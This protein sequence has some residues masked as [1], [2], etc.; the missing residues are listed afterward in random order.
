MGILINHSW[1]VGRYEA[2][3][4]V[5]H[6][7]L[8][9]SMRCPSA[10]LSTLTDSWLHVFWQFLPSNTRLLLLCR[11]TCE[12]LSSGLSLGELIV[13]CCHDPISSSL[14]AVLLY[15][16]LPLTVEGFFTGIGLEGTWGTSISISDPWLSVRDLALSGSEAC[17]WFAC[18]AELLL[19]D[20]AAGCILAASTSAASWSFSLLCLFLRQWLQT[21]TG[22]NNCCSGKGTNLSAQPVQN[23][24]PHCLQL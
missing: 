2:P 19:S 13:F 21:L 11:L 16:L 1:V 10:L 4:L 15:L 8:A 22:S 20:A 9:P 3:E 17:S 6:S 23:T 5:Q 24:C 14:E 18:L 7:A 12:L